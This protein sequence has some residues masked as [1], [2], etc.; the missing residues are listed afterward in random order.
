M[1]RGNSRAALAG[2]A[3]RVIR[4]ANTWKV[5]AGLLTRAGL[6]RWARSVERA[7]LADPE[8]FDHLTGRVA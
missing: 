2:R 7:C 5:R 3:A 6:T 8:S 4:R 1:T